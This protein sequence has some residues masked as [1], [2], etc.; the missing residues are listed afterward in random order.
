MKGGISAGIHSRTGTGESTVVQSGL[1]SPQTWARFVVMFSGQAATKPCNNTDRSGWSITLRAQNVFDFF[2]LCITLSSIAYKC[3]VTA[4]L[5]V[6]IKRVYIEVATAP[7]FQQ[8]SLARPLLKCGPFCHVRHKRRHIS[9]QVRTRPAGT[10]TL[11]KSQQR[12]IQQPV[13][14][15]QRRVTVSVKNK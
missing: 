10:L 11:G 8:Q 4:I 3:H 9:G 5:H 6:S 13:L 12:F 14:P 1:F 7:L 15:R 2:P